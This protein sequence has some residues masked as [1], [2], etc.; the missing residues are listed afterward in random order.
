MTITFRP[1]NFLC[2]Y[3]FQGKGYSPA[4]VD[5]FTQIMT[6]LNADENT[7]IEVVAG[8]DTICSACPHKREDA[9]TSQEKVLRIDAAHAAILGLSVGDKISWQEAKNRIRKNM[10]LEKFHEACRGCEWQPLGICEATL[11]KS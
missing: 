1:H 9:C 10:T 8:T 3:C 4:F 7:F 11:R 2:A 6:T 5:N